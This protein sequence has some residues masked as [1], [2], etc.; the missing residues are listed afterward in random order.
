MEG[1]SAIR[2]VYEFPVAAHLCSDGTVRY[3]KLVRRHG[4]PRPRGTCPKCQTD[5]QYR[6]PERSRVRHYSNEGGANHF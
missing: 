1:A 5:F 6:K 3:I 2:T 4:D